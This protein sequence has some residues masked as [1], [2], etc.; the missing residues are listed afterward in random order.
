MSETAFLQALLQLGH[1]IP[2]FLTQLGLGSQQFEPLQ[3]ADR[4]GHRQAFG[5]YLRTGIVADI[6]DD[7]FVTGHKGADRSHRFGE[8]GKVEI[9]LI[10]DALFFA[11]ARACR[12]EGAEAHGRRRR[13]DGIHRYP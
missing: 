9:D 4:Y 11:R 10:L 8:G 1:H 3:I 13:A 12:P 2:K 6:V 5:K 7:G